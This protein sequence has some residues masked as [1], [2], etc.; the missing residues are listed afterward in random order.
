MFVAKT[1]LY[2]ILS[3]K[4]A[5]EERCDLYFLMLNIRKKNEQLRVMARGRDVME[6]RGMI[7]VIKRLDL[8][9]EIFSFMSIKIPV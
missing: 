8:C 3:I 7:V 2:L 9:N 1:F 5:L 6:T 4:M